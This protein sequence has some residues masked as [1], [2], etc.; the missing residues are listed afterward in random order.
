MIIAL[1][2]GGLPQV[3][4]L[5]TGNYVEGKEIQVK[6]HKYQPPRGCLSFIGLLFP[7]VG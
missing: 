3:T 6:V 1:M 7:L 2:V 5:L 4:R